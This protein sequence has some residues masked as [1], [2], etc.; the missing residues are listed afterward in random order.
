MGRR[1]A[2]VVDASDGASQTFLVVDSTDVYFQ[3]LKVDGGLVGVQCDDFSVCRFSSMVIANGGAGIQI[4]QSRAQ[5]SDTTIRNTQNG[6]TSLGASSVR[7]IGGL[8]LDSNDTGIAV[9]GGSSMELVAAPRANTISNSPITGVSLANNASLSLSGTTISGGRDGIEVVGHSSVHL[10][11][12]NTIAG[13]RQ[14]GLYLF[15]LSFASFDPGNN[16]TGNN[17]RGGAL[18]VACFS[19]YTA[20]RGV[21]ANIGGGTTN[22]VE[23]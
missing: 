1:G 20:T 10:L 4:T 6:L 19:Q 9:D 21:F 16:I 11:A 12:A 17:Q 2:T 23:P 15:D 22:C 14:Y 18:D 7:V 13:N 3:G 8:T 5:V